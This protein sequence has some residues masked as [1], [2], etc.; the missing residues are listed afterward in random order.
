MTAGATQIQ[1]LV[2]GWI[3]LGVTILERP[4]SRAAVMAEVEAKIMTAVSGI[5]LNLIVFY[6]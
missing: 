3:F 5:N 2:R 6:R 1:D 4:G